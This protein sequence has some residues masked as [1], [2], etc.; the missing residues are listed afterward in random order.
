M[1]L[2]YYSSNYFITSYVSLYYSCYLQYIIKIILWINKEYTI[3]YFKIIWTWKKVDYNINK[4]ILIR[5][6]THMYSNP[7]CHRVEH[8]WTKKSLSPDIIIRRVTFMKLLQIMYVMHI[9]PPVILTTTKPYL[10]NYKTRIIQPH[11]YKKSFF[12]KF[13]L[14]SDK[15]GGLLPPFSP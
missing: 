7:D 15:S 9:H 3:A 8:Q 11:E 14:R 13:S 2:F 10:I 12:L 5:K 1:I 4:M 6:M